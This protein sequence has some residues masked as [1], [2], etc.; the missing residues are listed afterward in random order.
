[1]SNTTE[2]ARDM[3]LIREVAEATGVSQHAIR[4]M[5]INGEIVHI[6]CGRV[7]LINFKKFL[8]Y[9]D[10]GYQVEEVEPVNGIRKV[11]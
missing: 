11:M 10:T 8:E 3:R 4:Q 5:C 2:K 7:Y 9:L 1:M 6:R